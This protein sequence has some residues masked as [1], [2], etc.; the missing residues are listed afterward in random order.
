MNVQVAD[1]RRGLDL[2]EHVDTWH[3][4]E[5]MSKV[6]RRYHAVTGT[7]PESW[8]E[9]RTTKFIAKDFE[10]MGFHQLTRWHADRPARVITGGSP[11]SVMHP[12]LLRLITHR[13]TARVMGFPDDWRIWPLRNQ[14]NLRLTWGKGIPVSSGRW[15]SSW[16]RRSIAGHPGPLDGKPLDDSDPELERVIDCSRPVYRT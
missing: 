14:S 9:V 7:L 12:T 4:G 5:N 3:P 1:F 11:G 2:L 13:E 10:N 15:I 8:G 16:V 6:A